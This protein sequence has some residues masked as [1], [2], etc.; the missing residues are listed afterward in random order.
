MWAV[1]KSKISLNIIAE[2]KWSLAFFFTY[3]HISSCPPVHIHE[4]LSQV[5]DVNLNYMHIFGDFEGN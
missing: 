3:V 4:A 5:Q 2:A 1:F